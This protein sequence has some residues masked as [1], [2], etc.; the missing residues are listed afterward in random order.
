VSITFKDQLGVG[1]QGEVRK[2]IYDR[3]LVAAKSIFV[4][5]DDFTV[6]EFLREIKLLR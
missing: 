6:S 5:E 4:F 1:G 3:K 2:A